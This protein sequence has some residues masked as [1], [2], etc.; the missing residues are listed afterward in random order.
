MNQL[1]L[2]FHLHSDNTQ[3]CQRLNHFHTNRTTDQDQST[4]PTII[5][6][7]MIHLDQLYRLLIWPLDDRFQKKKIAPWASNIHELEKLQ[8]DLNPY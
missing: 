5:M 1:Q 7:K 2:E 6:D 4:S 3:T 8:Q